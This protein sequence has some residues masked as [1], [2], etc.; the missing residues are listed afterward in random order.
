MFGLLAYILKFIWIAE[1][2]YDTNNNEQKDDEGFDCGT[3]FYQ[4]NSSKITLYSEYCLHILVFL[5]VIG[6]YIYIMVYVKR[7]S[8]NILEQQM[9]RKDSLSIRTIFCVCAVYMLQCI[10]YMIVRGV[11]VD[12]MRKGF[13]IQFTSLPV[14]ICYIIYYTQFS[15]NVF[16]YSLGKGELLDSYTS[17][18]RQIIGCFCKNSRSENSEL[19]KFEDDANDGKEL[20]QRRLMR[21]V[22]TIENQPDAVIV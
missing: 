10:P 12:S 6:S 14:K 8:Q 13:F 19:E 22:E 7:V 21:N 9:T 3:F 15:L 20:V 5:I 1:I 18:L 16:I 2:L 11:Y 17:F 4:V